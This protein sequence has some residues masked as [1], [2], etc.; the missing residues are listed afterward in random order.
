MKQIP[1]EFL[2]GAGFARLRP[3]VY[4]LHHPIAERE[5]EAYGNRIRP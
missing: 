4:F 1:I 2:G 5:E 3:V